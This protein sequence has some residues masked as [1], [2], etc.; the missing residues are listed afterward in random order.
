MTFAT[1]LVA[2]CEVDEFSVEKSQFVAVFCVVAI[3]APSHRLRMM[4][5]DV[6]MFI[7]Q[8]PLFSVH[9]QGGMAIATGEHTLC[10][11]RRGNGKFLTCTTH[12]RDEIEP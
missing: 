6:G 3:Q 11:G 9:I 8:L 1:E 10:H 4:E 2:F 5:L 7:L 12:N